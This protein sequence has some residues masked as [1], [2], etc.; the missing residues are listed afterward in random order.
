MAIYGNN[1]AMY[2]HTYIAIIHMAHSFPPSSLKRRC[3][4]FIVSNVH[5]MIFIDMKFISK[6]LEI[7]FMQILSFSDP[8][9]HKI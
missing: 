3:F 2:G 6:L 7:L 9:P 1:V 5:F 4:E 8:H